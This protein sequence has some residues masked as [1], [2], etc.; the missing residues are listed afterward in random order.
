MQRRLSRTIEKTGMGIAGTS[1][2][3]RR[4]ALPPAVAAGRDAFRRLRAMD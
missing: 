2:A 3:S 4:Q 1:G